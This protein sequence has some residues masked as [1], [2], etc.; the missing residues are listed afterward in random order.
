M[1][2]YAFDLFNLYKKDL[3]LILEQNNK[4]KQV[5]VKVV[6]KVLLFK[7]SKFT[8]SHKTSLKPQS[9][10]QNFLKGNQIGDQDLT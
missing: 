8:Q 3:C 6:S 1:L 5:R 7:N 4:G 10:D 2:G 9:F